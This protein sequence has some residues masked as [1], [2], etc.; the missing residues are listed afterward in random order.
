MG[1]SDVVIDTLFRLLPQHS[2]SPRE[3]C[4]CRKGKRV[5][6]IDDSS[7]RRASHALHWATDVSGRGE[8]VMEIEKET[9]RESLER[10]KM[11]GDET[12]TAKR[13]KE[14]SRPRP[15]RSFYVVAVDD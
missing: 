10:Q 14:M 4:A 13:H 7:T 6:A 2:S 9:D 8:R 5:R 1:G 15:C 12:T 11:S 3:Y